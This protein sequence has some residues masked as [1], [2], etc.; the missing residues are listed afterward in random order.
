[1]NRGIRTDAAGFQKIG[2]QP[3][4][5]FSRE[6][7]GL[8]LFYAPGYLAAARPDK[9]EEI[10]GI[11]TG[12]L[13]FGCI[14]A[15]YLI[16][17]AVSAE[18]TWREIHDPEYYEPVCLALYPTL[19][20]DLDCTYCFARHE[21]NGSQLLYTAV[22]NSAWDVAANCEEKG[23]PFTVVFHGGGEPSLD[24]RLPHMLSELRGISA[25]VGIPFR[26]YIATNGV[27]EA[28]KARWIAENF[29]E[30]GLSLDGMPE[31]QNRQ[32]PLR[33]GRDSSPWVER[34]AA[35]LRDVKGRLSVRVTVLPENFS[36][37]PDIA[38]CCRETL[39]TD[40]LRVEPVYGQK[41]EAGAAEEFCDAFLQARREAREAGMRLEYSGSRIREVHGRYCRIFN[42][43][44]LLVPPQGCSACFLLSSESEA[45][46]KGLHRI[47]DPALF[48]R[49][50]R[51]D[52]ACGE[53]FNRFHC[54]RGCP[55]L[56]P[57]MTPELQ[58][59]GSFRCRVNRTM[60]EAELLETA[61]LGLYETART[62]GFAGIQ[63][64]PA[65]GQ[66]PFAER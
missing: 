37:I 56:C 32:R 57:V 47:G 13:P 44:L 26:S 15:H 62:H 29:D 5:V 21:H 23:I 49:L 58:D 43:T 14:A 64:I 65:D 2:D 17:S 25:E 61:R 31:I 18:S 41:T 22:M 38:A 51:E 46:R 9:A 45:E 40:V 24:P 53:C 34:T 6:A 7:D 52:P 54:A 11:L 33:G 50:S 60:A 42:Q 63:L 20:C 8:T 59:A 30:V 48:D 12:D 10:R 36:L 28:E 39:G 19:S 4:P 35:V 1:M 66:P 27:M 3:L 55:D 16:R